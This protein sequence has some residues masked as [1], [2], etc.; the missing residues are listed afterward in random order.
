M[1]FFAFKMGFALVYGAVVFVAVA[2]YVSVLG[3][4]CS[5]KNQ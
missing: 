4:V 1:F 5:Q 3:R 2:W